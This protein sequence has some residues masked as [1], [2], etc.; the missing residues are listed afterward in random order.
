M[1]REE[2]EI[3]LKPEV[4]QSIK[5]NLE[6]DP[7]KVALDKSV[8]HSREVASQVKNL[9]R[10]RQQLPSLNQAQAIIP[11]RGFEQSSSE[12]SAAAKP[13]TGESLLDLT[14]G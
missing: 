11:D 3:V 13:L 5:A 8:P 6:R 14:C 12:E 7:L 4:Q 2:L 9:R 10:A 1:R